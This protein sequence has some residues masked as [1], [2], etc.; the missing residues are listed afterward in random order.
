MT[1]S[2]I[3][4]YEFSW[5]LIGKLSSN[6]LISNLIKNFYIYFFPNPKT[7]Q[8][9]INVDCNYNCLFCYQR[10]KNIDVISTKKII[11]LIKEAKKLDVKYID[12]CH[13]LP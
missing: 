5:K 9:H 13:P 3:T 8:L 11:S 12:F 1:S 10:K 7:L 2:I 6:D 4:K